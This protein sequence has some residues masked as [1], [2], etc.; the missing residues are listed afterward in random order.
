LAGLS[1]NRK[2]SVE[3]QAKLSDHQIINS[4]HRRMEFHYTGQQLQGNLSLRGIFTEQ[5]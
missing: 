2:I 3:I 4:D 5:S 1:V